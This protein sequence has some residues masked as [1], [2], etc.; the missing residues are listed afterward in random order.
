M[1]SLLLN[2]VP[3]KPSFNDIE[4]SQCSEQEFYDGV[5]FKN[6]YI[7][8]PEN[9]KPNAETMRWRFSK[10]G[11]PSLTVNAKDFP[12]ITSICLRNLIEQHFRSKKVLMGRGF[13]GEIK[14]YLS[15]QDASVS[16]TYEIYD[17]FSL[18]VVR[19]DLTE[20][21]LIIGYKGKA[22]K[23][24]S[25]LSATTA[26]QHDDISGVSIGRYVKKFANLSE[27]ERSDAGSI[28]C[29]L[30]RRL[31]SRI[32]IPI[33]FYKPQ[34]KY[35]VFHD[36]VANFYT[37]Y[38]QNLNIAGII[39]DSQGLLVLPRDTIGNVT[40][41]GNLLSFKHDQ[42]SFNVYTG[43]SQF[44]P[45]EGPKL[46]DVKYIFIFHQEDKDVANKLFECLCKGYRQFPGLQQFVDVHFNSTN[47][48]TKASIHYSN[49][50]VIDDVK[51]H[52][53]QN[54][55]YYN[56]SNYFAFY[57]S[58]IKK[59]EE[60]ESKFQVYYK[61]KSLLLEHNILSQVIY[62]ENILSANFNY[63]LPNIA[64]A[65]LA[66]LGGKPWR[67]AFP[68]HSD[69][70][71]GIAASRKDGKTYLGS[72][73][74]FNNDGTFEEFDAYEE[75]TLGKLA[76]TL[77]KALITYAKLNKSC[78]RIVIHY[79]KK[80]SRKEELEIVSLLTSLKLPVPFVVLTISDSK[81]EDYVVFDTQY[82]GIIPCSGTYVRL[83][84]NEYI[85]CNNQ[86]Y[87]KN[88]PTR[89]RDFPFPIRI[90]FNTTHDSLTLTDSSKKE[91]IEQ[92]YQ[93][94]RIYWRSVS[95]TGEPVTL[96]YSELVAAMLAHFNPDR[97]PESR[98]SKKA[99]WFL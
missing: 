58:R 6:E 51:L 52:I 53:D 49:G 95:Q 97:L 75:N 77:S 84:K 90:F 26:I 99:L 28:Y 94:S 67:I 62:R 45:A 87:E 25:P 65:L 70:V 40:S 93:F 2:I 7:Y 69:L 74:V 48:D 16:K 50:S 35:K 86:R 55:E 59:D 44:G 21:G 46:N 29:F 57:I 22:Y 15:S 18:R 24:L 98:I 20:Y 43:L 12:R 11:E 61:L 80:L 54:A 14:L 8:L 66:K 31:A 79:Y 83:S 63:F 73:I 5:I 88:T 71:I 39:A 68:M 78:K 76:E 23:L 56:N 17:K 96:K 30:N 3:I 32:G 41:K 1:N 9:I 82:S 47:I 4:I 60:D 91:L 33:P 19:N 72:T 89:I 92:V 13:I 42:N 27:V 10:K 36:A 37:K 64:V 85:L 38:I 34:N 81:S